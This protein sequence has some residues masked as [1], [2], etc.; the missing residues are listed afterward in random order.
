[1]VIERNSVGCPGPHDG[2]FLILIENVDLFE[3]GISLIDIINA[4][5]ARRAGTDL[6]RLRRIRLS[7]DIRSANLLTVDVIIGIRLIVDGRGNELR[8]AFPEESLLCTR[9]PRLPESPPFMKKSLGT[10]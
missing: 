6:V 10:V 8:P 1:M 3:D 7:D 4:L 9:M 5:Q 2:V